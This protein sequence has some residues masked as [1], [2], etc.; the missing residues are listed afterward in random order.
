MSR[1]DAF[2]LVLI[3]LD[4]VTRDVGLYVYYIDWKVIIKSLC[5]TSWRCKGM[6]SVEHLLTKD[7]RHR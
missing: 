1:T 3:F 5:D 6:L 4:V 7:E 2:N